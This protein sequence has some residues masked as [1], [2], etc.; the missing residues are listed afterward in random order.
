MTLFSSRT[1]VHLLWVLYSSPCRNCHLID[2]CM[3]DMYVYV[4]QTIH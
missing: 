3:Y 4:N 2:Y 1:C